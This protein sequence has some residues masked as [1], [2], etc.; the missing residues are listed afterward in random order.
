MKFALIFI[1]LIG[2]ILLKWIRK[3]AANS[4]KHF[5]SF[6]GFIALSYAEEEENAVSTDVASRVSLKL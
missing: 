6:L 3:Y 5:Y 1:A 4:T 2:T